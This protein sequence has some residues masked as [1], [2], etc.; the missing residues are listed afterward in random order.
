MKR[1]TDRSALLVLVAAFLLLWLLLFS[2]REPTWD[3]VSYYVFARSVL[4]DGDLDMGNDFRLSYPTATPDFVAK[5]FDQ[6]LTITGRVHNQ[7]AIGS[8]LLWLPWLSTLGAVA[9]LIQLPGPLTGYE[10]F[11]VGNVGVLS[12]LLGVAAFWLS[13]RVARAMTGRW[14][15]LASAVTLLA[16]TPL[17]NYQFRVP[18]YSHTLSAFATAVC[19]YVWWRQYQRPAEPGRALLLGGLIGLAALVRWQNALF[20]LLPLLSAGMWWLGLSAA[21][22]H[23]RWREAAVYLLLVGLGALAVFSLQMSVWKVLSG[24]FL[25]IPQGEGFMEW[26]GSY[27]MP[28]LFSP[29]RGLLAWM[30]VFF[31]ALIGYIPLLRRSPRLAVPLLAVLLVSIYVNASTRDWFGGAGFGPRRFTSELTILVVGY[32][33]FLEL[34]PARV[35]KLSS[36]LLG[37]GLVFHHWLL[38]RFGMAERVGGRPLTM[39]PTFLWEDQPWNEFLQQ[40]GELAQR[41]VRDLQVFLVFPDSPLDVVLRH[42]NWPWQHLATLAATGLFVALVA[43]AGW[44]LVRRWGTETSLRVTLIAAA[45]ALVIGNLWILFFA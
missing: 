36:V 15:A 2:L 40:L 22:R 5:G 33:A 37:I 6:D 18:I 27:L 14:V 9:R 24:S 20:L 17:L 34:I 1:L 25:T 41:A 8:A 16:A 21:E 3:A 35:R 43:L 12:A 29:F 32:A 39:T 28:L 30:P 19:V 7:F 26:N 4:F 13:Y 45:A 10:R 31:L 38:L 44:W 11:F 23:T 42:Q